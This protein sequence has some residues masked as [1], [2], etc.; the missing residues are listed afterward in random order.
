VGAAFR[1]NSIVEL[2]RLI[3]I[4]CVDKVGYGGNFGKLD[5]AK[6]TFD[7][8]LDEA[9]SCK[10]RDDGCGNDPHHPMAQGSSCSHRIHSSQQACSSAVRVW[11]TCSACE[12]I[13]ARCAIRRLTLSLSV[14][15]WMRPVRR[16]RISAR[17]SS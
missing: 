11:C 8:N 17:L 5:R 1:E 13:F 16:P 14:R 12:R 9:N 10:W 3:C 6:E 2:V 15:F 4:R 7:G